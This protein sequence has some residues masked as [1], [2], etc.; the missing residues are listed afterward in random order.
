MLPAVCRILTYMLKENNKG[1]ND[2]MELQFVSSWFSN[3]VLA[4]T[5]IVRK[6][7]G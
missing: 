4:A 1:V 7:D 3:I 5:K 6:V 2:T